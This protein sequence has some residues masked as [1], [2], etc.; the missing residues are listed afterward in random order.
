MDLCRRAALKSQSAL[1]KEEAVR[2]RCEERAAFK[3]QHREQ[4]V[5]SWGGGCVRVCV[6]ARTGASTSLASLIFSV[7][8][9][10]IQSLL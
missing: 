6:C 8:A 7:P 4:G 2:G 3:A 1:D 9:A 10:P 5:F